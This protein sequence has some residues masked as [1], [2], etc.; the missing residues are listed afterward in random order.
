MTMANLQKLNPTQQELY[1]YLEQQTGQVNFEVLQPFTTQEMGAVLHISRNTV[2]QYLNE[3]FKEGWMVKINT[4][5]VYYFLRETLSRKF[6]VQTLD[7]EYEDLQFLQQDLNHGRRADSCFAGVIGYHLSLKS[8]VEK[9]RVAVEYPPTGLPLVL[10]GEKGTGKRLLAGKTWEYAKEKQV[11]PAESR[12]AELDCAMWG[13]AEPGGTGFAASFKRRLEAGTGSDFLY[14]HGFDQLESSVQAEAMRFLTAVL[15]ELGAKYPRLIFGVQTVPPSLKNSVPVQAE[16][17]PLRSRSLLEKKRLIYR[18]LMQEEQRIGRRVQVTGQAY[19]MLMQYPYERNV[20]QLEQVIRTSCTNAYSRSRDGDICIGLP[21][22][23]DAVFE[24]CLLLPEA[25]AQNR[26][27]TLDDL[28]EDCG[29]EREHH[30]LEEIREQGRLYLQGSLECAGFCTRM[31]HRLEEYNNYILFQN[32]IADERIKGIEQ[33]MLR[34]SE[35]I[36]ELY[37]V[38]FPNSFILMLARWVY[39]GNVFDDALPEDSA[40]MQQL[41][42]DLTEAVRRDAPYSF[43]VASDLLLMVQNTTD[44]HFSSIG[45]LMISAFVEV[46]HRPGNKLPVQA[47]IICHG[48][49]TAS[50]IADVCNKM[51]HKYLFNAIDMPYDVPVS[52]I[53]SQVKKILYFNENRDVLILV[54]LGSLENITELLDDL[55]NV[56]LGI[57][58][59]VSTAMAL[60]VGSHILDGMPLAE[61]LENAKN[62]SQIR[63]KILEKARKEDVIL[64]VSESGSNVAAKVSELFMH[65]LNHLNTKV[66][67]RFLC[68]DVQTYEQLRQNGHWDTCNVLFAASTMELG[69]ADFPVVAVEDIITQRGLDKIKSGLSGYLTEEE[70]E[71]F[72]QNLVNQFSLENVVESLTILNASR[73]L[74]LVADMLE[75]MQ[76]ALGSHFQPKTVVGLNL[77]ISCLIERLVKKRR[78]RATVIWNASVKSTGTLWHWRG[79][80]LPTLPSSTASTCRTVRS[81]I[82][83]IIFP[84]ITAM[85]VLGKMSFEPIGGNSNGLQ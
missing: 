52:E 39:F 30:L 48:Y 7:S 54:D 10:A 6:N 22:L 12:F 73:V 84:T 17:L 19:Q 44:V 11:V 25:G 45:I 83:T 59:N 55:P 58:N 77:H 50:S 61:V 15:P 27:L 78:S 20:G 43:A 24:S 9:C 36:H 69:P 4:R 66:N 34:I 82:F 8:A 65:S 42:A 1:N 74:S 5:P 64:F 60:S 35:R 28:R 14:L 47:F 57:I 31:V 63:Y 16:L 76:R 3:F 72:K 68:Y 32:K 67:A 38:G 81:A 21:V 40:E 79:A 75:E 56:N 13:A 29:F 26:A 51:L 53:V 41:V 80:A 37:G 18:F 70:F 71:H 23:P 2:S 33:G 85:K 46:L 49:A 62:A